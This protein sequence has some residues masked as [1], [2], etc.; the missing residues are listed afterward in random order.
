M[1]KVLIRFLDVKVDILVRLVL[2]VIVVFSIYF[3]TLSQCRNIHK[4]KFSATYLMHSSISPEMMRGGVKFFV[5]E[6]N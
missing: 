1:I 6:A 5:K 2:R 3:F 4:D